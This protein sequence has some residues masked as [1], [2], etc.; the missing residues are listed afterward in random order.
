MVLPD[1]LLHQIE[2]DVAWTS[3]M[4]EQVIPNMYE[5]LTPEMKNGMAKRLHNIDDIGLSGRRL[6]VGCDGI[7]LSLP[8]VDQPTSFIHICTSLV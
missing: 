1:G 5:P 6:V 7:Y 2:T 4:A 3:K 8:K